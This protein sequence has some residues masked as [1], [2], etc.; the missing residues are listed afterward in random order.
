MGNTEE[1]GRILRIKKRG[2]TGE[3]IDACT[4][5]AATQKDGDN[6]ELVRIYAENFREDYVRR[7]R[8]L[9]FYGL[10]VIV[11]TNL[12]YQRIYERLLECCEAM[13]FT[14]SYRFTE[15]LQQDWMQNDQRRH[16]SRYDRNRQ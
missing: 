5:Q 8:G 2:F 10:P 15:G 4:F 7:G 1:A 14:N 13:E 6:L 11:T 3:N 16:N 12:D 9:L